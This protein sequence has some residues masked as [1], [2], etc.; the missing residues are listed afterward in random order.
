MYVLFPHVG[1]V[2]RTKRPGKATIDELYARWTVAAAVFF[3]ALEL[4]YLV[5]V[6]FAYRLLWRIAQNESGE[7]RP[8]PGQAPL[9]TSVA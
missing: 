7:V 3:I 6:A 2:A 1:I 9:R 5:L 8:L 4:A